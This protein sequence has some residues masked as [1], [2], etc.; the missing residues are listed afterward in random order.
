M[1]DNPTGKEQQLLKLEKN[2]PVMRMRRKTT[3][4]NMVPIEYT[5][6]V[7]RGDKYQFNV[8][9]TLHESASMVGKTVNGK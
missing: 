3:L 7:Y 1:C 8:I 9:L 4:P 2:I 5:E 6:S